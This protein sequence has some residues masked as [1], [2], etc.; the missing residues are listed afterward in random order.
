[1]SLDIISLSIPNLYF[2]HHYEL[3]YSVLQTHP[4][5]KIQQRFNPRLKHMLNKQK[6]RMTHV[7]KKKR[8]FPMHTELF[9]TYM[10]ST[11]G[12]LSASGTATPPLQIASIPTTNSADGLATIPTRAPARF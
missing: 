2:N 3:R 8:V 7:R 10:S 11:S 1:M 12:K 4:I 5:I 6:K 9:I